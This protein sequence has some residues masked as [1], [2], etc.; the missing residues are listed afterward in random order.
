MTGTIEIARNAGVVRITINQVRRLNAMSEDMWESLRNE[1]A[2]VAT[3]PTDRVV[4]LSGSG[5]NFSSGSDMKSDRRDTEDSLT[6]VRRANAAA[7]ALHRLPQPTIAVVRGAAVG[8]GVSLALACDLVAASSDAYFWPNFTR[9]GFSPDV[10]ATWLLPRLVGLR[11]TQRIA[12]LAERVPASEALEIGMITAA[13]DETELDRLVDQW[14]G[15]LLE[16][17]EVA[18]TTTKT[19]LRYSMASDLERALESEALAQA[20][21]QSPNFPPTPN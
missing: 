10:G 2:A 13:V 20:V 15:A 8:G 12:L 6:R 5:R 21:N 7:L 14:I 3:T 4:V 17:S 18:L 1:L 16:K 19:L 9:I 11:Q